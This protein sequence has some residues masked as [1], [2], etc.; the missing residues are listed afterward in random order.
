ML[1]AD[2]VNGAA[3]SGSR[4][5]AAW[6]AVQPGDYDPS[7]GHGPEWG[8]AAP[9]GILIWLFMGTALFFLIKSMNRHLKRVPKAFADDSAHASATEPAVLSEGDSESS[10]NT[11]DSGVAASMT[12]SSA[13]ADSAHEKPE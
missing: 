10:A 8:K 5:A 6:V 2:L 1:A 9:A 11:V 4:L 7:S 13:S 3:Q 12:L